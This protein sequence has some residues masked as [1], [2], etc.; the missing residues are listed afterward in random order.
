M[1]CIFILPVRQCL[2]RNLHLLLRSRLLRVIYSSY[3]IQLCWAQHGGVRYDIT[4]YTVYL[5]R[6]ENCNVAVLP[7][8][9][10]VQCD[11]QMNGQ[12]YRSVSIRVVLPHGIRRRVYCDSHI[13]CNVDWL[14]LQY[15]IRQMTCSVVCW[16]ARAITV[17]N[18]VSCCQ[19]VCCCC[20]CCVCQVLVLSKELRIT[21]YP[22]IYNIH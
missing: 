11:E 19:G 5:I 20:S 17:I 1:R 2:N 15:C 10:A 7:R 18:D 16:P 9:I 6:A 8:Q 4:S 14:A 3:F 12:T 13:L 22:R 21:R